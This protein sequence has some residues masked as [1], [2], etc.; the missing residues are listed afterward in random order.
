[1]IVQVVSSWT[2]IDGAVRSERAA[3][4]DRNRE[5]DRRAH[6]KYRAQRWS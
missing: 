5:I 1:M 6:A 2:V 3:N 4:R